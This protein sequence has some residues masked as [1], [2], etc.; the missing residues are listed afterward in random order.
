MS[1]WLPA[2]RIAAREAWGAKG[3]SLLVL[4]L[5]ALPVVAT[6]VLAVYTTTTDVD[7]EESLDRRLGSAQAWVWYADTGPLVQASD[8]YR[9][10][11]SP[12][13]TWPEG[14]VKGPDDLVAALPEG[15]RQSIL[16]EVHKGFLA[17]FDEITEDTMPGELSNVIAG[18][19]ANL[20]NFRGPNF[21]T[22]AACASGLA[23]VWQAAIGRQAPAPGLA[24]LAPGFP[25]D[26]PRRARRGM[27]PGGRQ[28]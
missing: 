20:F 1:G 14:E 4:L 21:T 5:V 27:V 16:A 3:R 7:T 22:D 6:V 15:Q 18:R 9:D 11:Y 19:I 23:A 25:A 10:G 2:L 24:P 26:Q 12:T 17:N 8:P 28:R 13:D